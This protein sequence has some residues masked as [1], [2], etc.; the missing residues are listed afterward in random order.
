VSSNKL[1]RENKLLIAGENKFAVPNL[2]SAA[3]LDFLSLIGQGS[4]EGSNG[5]ARRIWG[6]GGMAAVDAVPG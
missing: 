2:W 5:V 6:G 3:D 1:H 4:D